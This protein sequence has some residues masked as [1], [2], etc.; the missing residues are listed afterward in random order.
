[1]EERK[2]R[3]LGLS[4][5]LTGFARIDLLGTGM[6]DIY[7]CE[8]DEVLPAN[9]LDELLDAYWRLSK[10]GEHN[11]AAASE[12]L[13][14]PK[15]GPVARNLILLWYCG[16]W[17]KLP[18]AWCAAYGVSS[19]DRDADRVLSAAAYQAALQWVVAGAH[20][21]GAQQQGYG[22]WATAPRRGGHE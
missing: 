11:D 19:Q 16:T 5:L 1:M 17:T 8:L 6:T 7:F 9:T 14:D 20:P 2:E 13:G 21:A 12:I 15:L 22:A 10:G 4:E 3:I 18:G